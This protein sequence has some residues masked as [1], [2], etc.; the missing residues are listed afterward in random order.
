MIA[1]FEK[2]PGSV[3]NVLKGHHVVMDPA[4]TGDLLFT[5]QPF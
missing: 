1:H 4:R 5:N 2:A 3:S